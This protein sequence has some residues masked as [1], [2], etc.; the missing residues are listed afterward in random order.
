MKVIEKLINSIKKLKEE[1]KELAKRL[2]EA[3]SSYEES[4]R[5]IEEMEN[6]FKVKIEDIDKKFAEFGRR[7]NLVEISKASEKEVSRIGEKLILLNENIQVREKKIGEFIGEIRSGLEELTQKFGDLE[8][9]VDNFS[10]TLKESEEKY[11]RIEEL[12]SEL[13]KLSEIGLKLE[14][15][16][17]KIEELSAAIASFKD[18]KEEIEKLKSLSQDF[19]ALKEKISRIE[20]ELSKRK[21]IVSEEIKKIKESVASKYKRVEEL[22]KSFIERISSLTDALSEKVNQVNTS[23]LNFKEKLENLDK[24]FLSLEKER[25]PTE[26]LNEILKDSLEKE[27]DKRL[28]DIKAKLSGEISSQINEKI[29]QFDESLAK[30]NTDLTSFKKSLKDEMKKSFLTTNEKVEKIRKS[31][32]IL[33]NRF[34]KLVERMETEVSGANVVYNKFKEDV[35]KN[36]GK[37][38]ERVEE[39]EK[40]VGKILEEKEDISALQELFTSKFSELAE[41]LEN[42]RK[43]IFGKVAMLMKEREKYKE[44]LEKERKSIRE[45]I[46]ELKK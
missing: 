34:E 44:A 15:Q 8:K 5:K 25:L 7:L 45:M 26:K 39:L 9:R 29:S 4:L 46:K 27:L 3:E 22:Q 43:V 23:F 32:S 33:G 19:T 28:E 31:V 21:E 42:A 12:S 17:K 16:D 30:I 38:E 13:Q 35:E 14:S 41:R 20:D 36:I 2:K 11:K 18:V 40:K 1:K 24:K 37:M 10:T 6:F